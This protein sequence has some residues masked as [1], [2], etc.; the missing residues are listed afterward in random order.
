[1]SKRRS[2][3]VSQNGLLSALPADDYKRI[4]PSLELVPLKLREMLHKPGSPI[5][6]VYFPAAASAP[7]SPCWKTAAWWRWRRLDAEGMVGLAALSDGPLRVVGRD[8]ASETETCYRM[9]ASAFRGEMDRLG[10]FYDLLNRYTQ[11]HMGFIMQSTAC[12]AMHSVEQRLARGCCW[13]TTAWRPT[14]F[15]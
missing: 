11:A 14:S 9:A 4:A 5:E 8:G 1:M 12:N 6:Y 7:S 13:R 2:S 10:A 3:S 15:P